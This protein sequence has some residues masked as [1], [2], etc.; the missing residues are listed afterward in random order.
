MASPQKHRP[1]GNP[2]ARAYRTTYH[3]FG[4][5]K[6]YNFPLYILTAGALFAFALARLMYLDV[7]GTFSKSSILG[8]YY[9]YRSGFRHVG[10]T[11]HL[12]GVLFGSLLAALQFTPII[13]KKYIMFHRINGYFAMLLFLLGNV[14]AFM[15]IDQSMGG[16]PVMR[17]WI[18][19][20]GVA[21]TVSIILAYI[22]VKRL[23]IDQH[24]AWMIR[25]FVWAGCIITLRIIL[26]ISLGV[27]SGMTVDYQ[28]PMRCDQLFFIY[29][30]IGVPDS[31][32]PIPAKY[33]A[34]GSNAAINP[35]QVLVAGN[36]D[37]KEN[38][39][40]LMRPVF[41]MAAWLAIIIHIFLGELYLW[42]TPAESHRLRVVSRER[43]LERGLI[44]AEDMKGAG[45]GSSRLGDAP[46]WWNKDMIEHC[47]ERASGQAREHT[48]NGLPKETEEEGKSIDI[49]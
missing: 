33:P 25:T 45:L 36:F 37:A 3:A 6:A 4:F 1:A 26:G 47:A 41:V 43:Q 17:L 48:Q 18:G 49:A 35:T 38:V 2:V 23:Q 42:L 34:C 5:Q 32:N 44:T 29:T 28:T 20:L 10:I 30:N 8:E 21:T 22:N 16:A 7:S 46:E 27:L 40:A 39:A 19:A 12:I 13:R 24:R 14:G 31:K 15:I 11:L 9:W